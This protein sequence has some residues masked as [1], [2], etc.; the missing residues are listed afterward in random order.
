MQGLSRRLFGA[1]GIAHCTTSQFTSQFDIKEIKGSEGKGSAYTE[2][3]DALG[4]VRDEA[5]AGR[6]RWV[7]EV[8]DEAVDHQHIQRLLGHV[9]NPLFFSLLRQLRCR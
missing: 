8:L 5:L 1:V 6:C 7:E 9:Q 3:E 4:T 2:L